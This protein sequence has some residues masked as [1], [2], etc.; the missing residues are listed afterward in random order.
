MKA[1][2]LRITYRVEVAPG[3]CLELPEDIRACVGEGSWLVT[4][5]PA[6]P[7][8]GLFRD[9]E[10]FLRSYA[11]EDEGLYDDLVTASASR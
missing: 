1:E 3:E 2:P 6:P 9:H 8:G 11:P 10:A 7:G 4:V 5:E